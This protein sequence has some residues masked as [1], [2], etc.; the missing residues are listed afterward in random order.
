MKK[1]IFLFAVLGLLISCSDDN[2]PAGQELNGTWT[3][4]KYLAYIFPLPVVEKGDIIYSIDIANKN[5]TI[6]SK[7]SVMAPGSYDFTIANNILTVNYGS[8]KEKLRYF[9]EDDILVIQSAEEGVMDGT[10][11]KLKRYSTAL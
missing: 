10:V 1:L 11:I 3:V 2:K 8:H 4:T 6:Q 7:G 9:F 5:L